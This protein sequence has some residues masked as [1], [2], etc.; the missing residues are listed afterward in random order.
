MK[1][2]DANSYNEY[3]SLDAILKTS[4]FTNGKSSEQNFVISHQITE[5]WFKLLI[6]YI[7]DFTETQHIAALLAAESIMRQINSA[8][9][10]F[11]H[12]QAKDFLKIREE[13]KGISGAESNQYA[14]VTDLIKKSVEICNTKESI[15]A[16]S[17]IDSTF[18]KWKNSHLQIT[19]KLI[20]DR[21]GTGGTSG[22][23]FI[24]EQGSQ[25]LIKHS[26]LNKI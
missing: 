19:L 1:K 21:P 17:R 13:L 4:E 18:Q 5:L 6:T 3:L 8:W 12:I 7:K 2:R 20:G 14:R 26:D 16:L 9:E 23:D 22:A 24:K 10:V 25:S 11:E 15:Q